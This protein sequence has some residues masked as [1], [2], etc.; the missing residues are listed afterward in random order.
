MEVRLTSKSIL[1]MP[2]NDTLESSKVTRVD[3]GVYRIR[4]QT[5]HNTEYTV[6]LFDNEGLGGCDCKNF[7]YSL[8]PKFERAGKIPFDSYRCKHIKR[9][10]SYV[11]DLIILTQTQTHKKN[12]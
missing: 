12:G 6:D 10:R 1:E 11:L 9:V 2:T 4:S 8:L 5:Q 3:R 7:M